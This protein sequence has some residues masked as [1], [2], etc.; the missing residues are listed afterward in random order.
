MSHGPAIFSP[1]YY[2][3]LDMLERRHW[4]CRSVRRVALRLIDEYAP[5][6]RLVLDAGCGTGGFLAALTVRRQGL[7]AVGA[8]VSF[9]ALVRARARG[10]AARL[11][12]GSVTALPVG[13]GRVDLVISHD[14]LQHLPSGEDRGALAEAFRVLRPRGYLCLRSNLGASV[15]SGPALARRYERAD[16][17]R[18]V[19]DAGFRV[20]EHIVLHPLARAWSDLSRAGRGDSHAGGHQGL[21][22]TLPPAPVNLAMQVFT[23]LEDA[24]VRRWPSLARSGDVQVVFAQ[25]ADG[26]R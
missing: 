11:V 22:L 14:V 8:D 2:E 16:L 17:S 6:A 21:S 20:L 9:D 26:S 3:R 23:R 13:S 19:A 18:L 25:K 5:E 24:F 7:F 15:A 1:E 10:G 4:W 12:G